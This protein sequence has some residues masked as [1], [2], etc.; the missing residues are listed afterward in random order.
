MAWQRSKSL[1]SAYPFLWTPKH[2]SMK[3]LAAQ[4]E[5]GS[6]RRTVIDPAGTLAHMTQLIMPQHANSLGITFG[7]QASCLILLLSKAVKDSLRSAHVSS[8][9][10]LD[11]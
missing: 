6:A 2:A 10:Q 5:P 11:A 9:S 3:R 1:Q 8:K 7:G 4:V